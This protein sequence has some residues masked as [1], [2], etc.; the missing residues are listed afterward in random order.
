MDA[1][2]QAAVP[3]TNF[4]EL[5]GAKFIEISPEFDPKGQINK[6]QAMAWRHYSLPWNN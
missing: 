5:K 6:V 3:N 1:I 4:L 2:A